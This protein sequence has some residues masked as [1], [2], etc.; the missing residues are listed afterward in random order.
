MSVLTATRL[1]LT[2][3]ADSMAELRRLRD[4][5]SGV[6]LV[7]LRLDGVAD[8]DVGGAL[9]GRRL[10]VIVTCRPTWEGGRFAGSESERLAVLEHAMALGAEF[11]DVEWRAPY[12]KFLEAA[13]GRRVVLSSHDFDQCP[14]DLVERA[15]AMLSTG[16]EIVKIAVRAT[17]LADSVRLLEAARALDAHGRIVLIGMGEPGLVTRVCASRF[18]S[19][20]SYAGPVAGVG[21]LD[22][23]SMLH[24][25]RFRSLGPRTELYGVIGQPVSHSVSPA[26]HNAAFQAM[27]RDAVYLPLPASDAAD[28]VGFVNGLDVKGASITIPYKVDLAARVDEIDETGRLT[29]AINTL[30]TDAGR[31]QGRNTD[32]EG[33]LQPLLDRGIDLRGARAAVLGAGGSARSVV[34]GLSGAGAIVTIHARARDKA[35]ALAAGFAA[36]VAAWPPDAGTWDLLVNCTP[37]GMHPSADQ[38]PV[39]AGRLGGR[40]VYDLVYNPTD[41]RLLQDAARSGCG[42]IGGLDM[43]VAQA[44]AQSQW[45]TGSRPS[46]GMM[47]SAALARL[48]EFIAS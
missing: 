4:S 10:P 32:V 16:A 1:C 21:Q 17:C 29:G 19:A 27:G 20:W 40:W 24:E 25:Y 26:M 39:P 3:Q 43:L 7:E 31:W 28:A 36:G 12:G 48:R 13:G 47:R 45:W 22:V 38:S 18:G 30:R 41:T 15:R 46:A 23:A 44:Q 11:V 42:T 34:A 9:A 8:L 14:A 33:F 2:V 35:A 37:V 5:A 6:D